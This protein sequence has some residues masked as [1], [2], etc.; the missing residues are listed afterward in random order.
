MDRK[1]LSELI[2]VVNGRKQV[3]ASKDNLFR[4]LQQLSEGIV[5]MLMRRMKSAVFVLKAPVCKV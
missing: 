2:V 1:Y 4:C 3:Y 5:I